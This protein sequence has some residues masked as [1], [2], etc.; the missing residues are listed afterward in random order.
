[1][2]QRTQT[3]KAEMVEVDQPASYGVDDQIEAPATSGMVRL[4]DGTVV[5]WRGNYTARHAGEHV[6]FTTGPD[7]EQVETTVNVEARRG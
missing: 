3:A 1:M 5:T 7:G 4:P 2:A 6:F